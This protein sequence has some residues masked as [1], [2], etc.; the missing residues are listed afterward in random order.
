MK[1]KIIALL[2]AVAALSVCVTGCGENAIPD[3]TDEEL[4]AIG[5]YAA[6]TLMKYDAGNR[7]RLVELP[8]EHVQEKPEPVEEPEESHGM[9]QVDD[10]PVIDAQGEPQANLYTVEE[11]LG[12]AEDVSVTYTGE[13]VCDEYPQENTSDAFAMPPAG[14]GERYLVLN[15]TI[16]NGSDQACLVD[17]LSQKSAIYKI[18]VNGSRLGNALTTML[19]NDMSTVREYLPAGDSREVVLIIEAEQ[20]EIENIEA[21]ELELKN[22]TKTCTIRLK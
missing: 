15:F 20:S 8:K 7:S 6:V 1:K 5:E 14:P 18:T 22:D 19:P 17:I 11:V 3:M 10:T 16:Q 9:G 21:I 4:Q 12:L 13:L 2:L